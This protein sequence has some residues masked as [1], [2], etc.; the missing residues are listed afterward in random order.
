LNKLG[1][2]TVRRNCGRAKQFFRAAV[3][4]RFIQENPFAD[5]KGCAVKATTD[6]FYFISREEAA[7]V[8]EACP[9]AQWRLL[10]ALSRYGGLRCTKDHGYHVASGGQGQATDLQPISP[11][12]PSI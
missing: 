12:A 9:D 11:L 6:R 8:L 7:K 2:N 1:E 4:K 10:F 5:M 3:R